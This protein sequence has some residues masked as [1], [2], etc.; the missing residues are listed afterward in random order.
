M[1]LSIRAATQALKT[2]LDV[3]PKAKY[4]GSAVLASTPRM[5]ANEF[6]M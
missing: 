4:K 2:S 6:A 3:F 1:R 5:M